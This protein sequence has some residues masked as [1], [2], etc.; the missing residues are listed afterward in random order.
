MLTVGL[1]VESSEISDYKSQMKEAIAGHKLAKVKYLIESSLVE[2]DEPIEHLDTS[3]HEAIWNH[4]IDIIEYLI[5]AK[6]DVN[7][8]NKQGITP[9]IRLMRSAYQYSEKELIQIVKL[10]IS[11]GAE[12][13]EEDYL[14]VTPLMDAAFSA[15]NPKVI[16]LLIDSGAKVNI[17]SNVLRTPLIYAAINGDVRTIEVLVKNG[18][19]IEATD[20]I[21]ANAFIWALKSGKKSVAKYFVN[22]LGANVNQRDTIGATP[23]IWTTLAGKI[24]M[25]DYLLEM[26]ADPNIR[27]SK[28]AYIKI[29]EYKNGFPQFFPTKTETVPVGATALTFAKRYNNDDEIAKILIKAGAIE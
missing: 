17:K 3:L 29:T 25:V 12:V 18:A 22:K 4:D 23:L 1:R 14:G 8:S 2:I 21:G 10:L 16:Q 6:A 15:V 7:V 13:N 5:S 24:N 19:D 28:P 20:E 27:I 11:K 26:G 9:L